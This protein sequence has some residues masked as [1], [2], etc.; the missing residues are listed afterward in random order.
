MD[1]QV[2]CT[3]YTGDSRAQVLIGQSA[4][5][6]DGFDPI[7]DSEAPPEFGQMFRFGVVNPGWGA[8]AGRYAV[9]IRRSGAPTAWNLQIRTPAPDMEVVLTWNNLRSVPKGIRLVLLDEATGRRY[10]L[11]TVSSVTL[12]TDSLGTRNLQL[13]A[14]PQSGGTLRITGLRAQRTRG[15]AYSIQYTLSAD[16]QVQAEVLSASGKP[17]R[18]L[19]NGV[20]S[21]A[22]I[23]SVSWDGR[24]TGGVAVP[25]GAYLLRIRAHTEDGTLS[26]AILPMVVTR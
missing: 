7:F 24:D 19:Q 23:Q 10:N 22:G 14:E 26:Q 9:D 17:V 2:T 15:G 11:R 13:V 8:A 12:R 6:S 16:A 3:A 1:W 5:A 21:R 25:A 20:P 4:S 18:V